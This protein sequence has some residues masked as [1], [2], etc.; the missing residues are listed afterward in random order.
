MSDETIKLIEQH[1]Q[2]I[3]ELQRQ[4]AVMEAAL[5]GKTILEKPR[6]QKIAWGVFTNPTW[7]W[8]ITDYKVASEPR[9]IYV[10]QSGFGDKELY[11]IPY[12]S[13]DECVKSNACPPENVVKFVEVIE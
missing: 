10:A 12:F 8:E 11:G 7:N 3:A 4:I 6:Y 1:R 13:V 9:T 2:A 5:A